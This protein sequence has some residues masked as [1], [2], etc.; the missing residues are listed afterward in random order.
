M[1]V[2]IASDWKEILSEEFEKPYFREL[3]DFVRQEYASRR[4]FPRGSNIFRAFDKCPFDK[5]KVVIIG[6]DPYH[7]EGQ[8]N[9]LCFSVADGVP[10]PPS[11]QNIF[12]EVADDTGSPI[13]TSGNLDRWAEQGVLLLSKP[14]SNTLFLQA[15]HLA[16]ASNHRL[17]LLRQENARMQEKIAQ[18]R[19]VSHAKCCLVE[20][21]QMSED[22]AHRYIEKHAMDTRRSRAEI[23]QEILDSYED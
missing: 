2:K 9:G 20:R 16:A 4:I 10:F 3:T 7:G 6:Q 8:A 15:I 23:A 21:E 5:L 14:F 1:D 22:A 18:V 12:Q 17:Q 13:P 11:L 19:L